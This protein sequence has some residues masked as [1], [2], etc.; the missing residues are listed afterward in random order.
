MKPHLSVYYANH[1]S[2]KLLTNHEAAIPVLLQ[3]DSPNHGDDE[4]GSNIEVT[5]P[6]DRV[7]ATNE[8]Y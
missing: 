5:Q 8:I 3:D 6:D 4:Q 7:F 2:S 1:S